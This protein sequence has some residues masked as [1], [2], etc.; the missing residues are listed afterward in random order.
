L[1]QILLEAPKKIK[2]SLDD[3]LFSAELGTVT[4]IAAPHRTAVLTFGQSGP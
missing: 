4:F 2:F 1:K 3:R